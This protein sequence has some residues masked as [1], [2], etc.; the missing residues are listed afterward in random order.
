MGVDGDSA[1]AK[2]QATVTT[3]SALDVLGPLGAVFR[4]PRIL[5]LSPAVFLIAAVALTLIRG[6]TYVARSSFQ[7]QGTEQSVLGGY[8]SLA[9]Q[10]GVRLP[11]GGGG[12]SVD[13]YAFLIKAPALLQRLALHEF[14]LEDDGETVRG[15]L[16]DL[17]DVQGDDRDERLR[18]G[19]D[20]LDVLVQ[21]RPDYRASVVLIETSARTPAL[22]VALNRQLLALITEFDRSMRQSTAGAERRFIQDRLEEAQGELRSAESALERFLEVNRSY[23]QSPQLRFEASRLQRRIDLAQQLHNSLAQALAQA[24]IE[25]VRN[26]P[27][28]TVID[29]PEGMVRAESRLFQSSVFAVFLGLM[30]AALASLAMEHRPWGRYVRRNAG[31]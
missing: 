29:A 16:L 19:V 31:T 24:Q 26:T 2:A 25:E 5:I 13:F 8:A 6:P 15:N 18:N 23:E 1:N 20:L 10:F 14:E 28:T 27:V 17:F 9:A 12:R 22:A 4:H 7:P 11:L 21:V 3:P 30:V